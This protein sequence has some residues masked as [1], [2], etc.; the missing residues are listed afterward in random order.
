MNEIF[1]DKPENTKVV[2]FGAGSLTHIIVRDI[3]C[4]ISMIVDNDK[5]KQGKPV[6]SILGM[7]I[8]T[9]DG[10]IHNPNDIIDLTPI[11]EILV[12]IASYHV[13]EITEQLSDLGIRNIL[14]GTKQISFDVAKLIDHGKKIIKNNKICIMMGNYGEHGYYLTRELLSRELDIEIVWIIKNPKKNIPVG[15]R[16]VY[17]GD[18]GKYLHEM[19]TSKLWIFDVLVP[20]YITKQVGQCYIQVKHWGSITLKKFYRDENGYTLNEDRVAKLRHNMKMLDF[21]VVGSKFD[22]ETCRSGFG[23]KGR[24][25]EAGSPRTDAMFD[26]SIG[27][28]VRKQLNID[29]LTKL[30]LY[31]P[32]YREEDKLMEKLDFERL[33]RTLSEKFGGE[34]IILFRYHPSK[35]NTT[36]NEAKNKGINVSLYENSQE[37]CAASDIM[38]TDYSSIMFES[39]VVKKPVFLFSPDKKEYINNERELLIDYESLPFPIATTNIELSDNILS[40]DKEKY[41]EEV[42]CFLN[43]Y[44]VNEDGHACKR[45]VDYIL[46][47][48]GLEESNSHD[49]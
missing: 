14:D 9:I 30:A 25:I 37:L 48:M 27:K 35:A 38:I 23:Y 24:F 26:L 32:T 33:G 29:C 2:I 4:P 42:T 40:F 7:G 22:K 36:D 12:V 18:F 45:T 13:K 20:K 5:R 34:W 21:I 49:Y 41:H 15:V 39:A 1:V 43:K 19:S 28:M 10:I 16:T 8:E 46:N 31:A 17:D 6:A 44:G 11:D 47:Y 3:K